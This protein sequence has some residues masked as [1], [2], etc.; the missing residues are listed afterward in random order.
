MIKICRGKK[1]LRMCQTAYGNWST[2][3]FFGRDMED[4]E[5]YGQWEMKE[6]RWLK[7]TEEPAKYRAIEM[8]KR[9]NLMLMMGCEGRLGCYK[10]W[11]L[12]EKEI[13]YRQKW[14]RGKRQQCATIMLLRKIVAYSKRKVWLV[15]PLWH[16][17][18]FL[19]FWHFE[20]PVGFT[21][22]CSGV[23][24][25]LAAREGIGENITP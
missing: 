6:G 23:L 7:N 1:K 16:I 3:T 11:N 21:S 25:R 8:K 24:Q 9:T 17:F 22:N 4:W 2:V 19:S 14:S 5:P 20:P 18:Q 15:L 13:C 12:M 10:V